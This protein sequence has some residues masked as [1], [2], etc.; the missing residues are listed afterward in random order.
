M[1]AAGSVSSTRSRIAGS[2]MKP[3]LTTSP[4]PATSSARGSAAQRS[5]GRTSTPAGSWKEPTRFLPAR[6]VDAG[7]AAD[8]R[9]DH[10]EQRGRDVHDPHAAQPGRGHEAAE[11]GGRAAA[12]GHDRVGAGEAGLAERLPARRRDRGGLGLLAVGDRQRRARRT[13]RPASRAPGGPARRAR[14]EDH[15]HPLHAG[16]EHAGSRPARSCPTTT[17]YGDAPVTGSTVSLTVLV[18]HDRPPRQRRSI[19]S[20]TSSGV[21][22]SVST[23][24]GRDRS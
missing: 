19:S 12:D 11:V 22:P 18:T 21:R 17:S 13:P 24:S 10:A 5:R 6:G 9:V 3:H 4:R 8:R 14:R 15:R 1:S 16:A 20:A 7:L 2:A 23:T